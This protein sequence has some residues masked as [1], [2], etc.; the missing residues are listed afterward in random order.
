MDHLR[1]GPGLLPMVGF[2]WLFCFGFFVS[3]PVV[4]VICCVVAVENI[5]QT[6]N[7]SLS[8]PNPMKLDHIFIMHILKV[9]KSAARAVA[10][11][12]S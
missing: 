8:T 2:F 12:F 6:L 5:V 3:P 1:V 4:Q 7:A 11:F 10:L 9:S